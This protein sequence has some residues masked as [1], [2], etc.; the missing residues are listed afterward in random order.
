MSTGHAHAVPGSQ[1]ERALWGAFAL[2]GSFLVVEVIGGYLAGSLALISDAAHMLTDTAAIGLAIAAIRIG[3][4]PPD[5]RRTFGYARTEILAATVNALLLV[6]VAVYIMWEAWQRVRQPVAVQSW[7]MLGIATM[8]LGVNL[9]SMRLLQEGKDASLNVKG[10]YLEVWS[11]MLGSIG[12]ILAALL[13]RATGWGW[14]D[15]LVA[16]A[17]AL[18]VLPRTW[19]LLRESLNVLL[20][21]VPEGIDLEALRSNLLGVTGVTSVHDLHAWAITSGW[22]S[23][24]A[25]VVIEASANPVATLSA[26]RRTLAEEHGIRHATF[27]LE[28]GEGPVDHPAC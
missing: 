26:L 2:T 7:V 9:A 10:A 4:R 28:V 8:G 3:R 23:V 12:V 20:E 13:I 17:I 14:L 24:T 16:V 22:P 25:H 19:V 5:A 15:P 18:W 21:G 27:Q 1:N 11:D 6:A